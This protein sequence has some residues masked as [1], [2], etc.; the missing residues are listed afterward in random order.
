[1]RADI[2][3]VGGVR[4]ESQVILADSQQPGQACARQV[5]AWLVDVARGVSGNW[6]RLA[7][8]SIARLV[9]VGSGPWVAA[10]R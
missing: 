6:A 10:L 9:L 5:G 3:P 1:M 8:C 2:Q 7:A 4:G